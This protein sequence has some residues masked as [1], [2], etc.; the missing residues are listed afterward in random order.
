MY[1]VS[2]SDKY[3]YIKVVEGKAI[4]ICIYVDDMLIIVTDLEIVIIY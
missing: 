1:R 3:V 2:E 4:V